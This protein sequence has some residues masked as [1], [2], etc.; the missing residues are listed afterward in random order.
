MSER[1]QTKMVLV[2]RRLF[3]GEGNPKKLRAGKYVAQAAHAAVGLLQN[4]WCGSEYVPGEPRLDKYAFPKAVQHWLANDYRKICVYVDTEEE[5]LALQE[6]ARAAG[7]NECLIVDNGDTE[8][9][10]QPTVTVLGLGPDWN[11]PL[12]ALTGHLPLL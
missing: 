2:C 4:C 10:G 9:G 3:P 12:D 6:Q 1:Y 8:F 11:E 5:L 7:V